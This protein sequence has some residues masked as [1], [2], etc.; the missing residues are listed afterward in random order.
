LMAWEK[1]FRASWE[2]FRDRYGERFYRMW[3]YYLLS[4]AAAFRAR[5]LQLF[6]FVFSKGGVLDGY[7]SVRNELGRAGFEPAKA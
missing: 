2:H 5:S 6:Q 7:H 3:R 4:S 1:N